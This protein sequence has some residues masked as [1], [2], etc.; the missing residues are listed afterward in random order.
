MGQSVKAYTDKNDGFIILQEAIKTGMK[1]NG[2]HT[3]ILSL[4]WMQQ[5][6]PV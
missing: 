2:T 4:K 1:P 5:I 3:H 6:L